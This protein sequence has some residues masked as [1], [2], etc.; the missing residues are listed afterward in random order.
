MRN[1]LYLMSLSVA[2]ASCASQQ[3][4]KKKSTQANNPVPKVT[5]KVKPAAPSASKQQISH[6]GNY[7]FYKVNIGDVSKNDN[8]ISYGSIVSANPRGYKVVKTFFPA[9]AQNFRQKYIILH[10]TALDDDKSVTVLTQQS[11]SAHYLVNNLGDRDIYQLVDENKRSYH[12][13]ISAWRA[14]KMLND[15]SIGIEIVNQGYVADSSGN[16][17]FP[18]FDNHQMKK[19]AALVKDIADRYMIPPT[20]I[21]AH[22]DIAPTRKSDPGPKFPWKKLY[23]EYQIGMWYDEATKQGFYDQII[24]ENYALEMDT[25]QFIY[26]YQAALKTLGYGLEPSGTND[27]ATKKTI[28]AFQFHFRPEKYD[29]LMDAET[30][31]ILQALNV[32]YPNK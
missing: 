21:L 3:P 4:V 26:K 16:R 31:A 14:D 30:W 9:V 17:T 24:P 22:S 1:T 28:E 2:L 32:K 18:E 15:T 25:A 29:G 13:G 27:D 11:V 23:D 7:D 19:V 6:E 8:T 5:T 10:Y 20:N 12:A